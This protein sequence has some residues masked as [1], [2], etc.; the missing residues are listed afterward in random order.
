MRV[1]VVDDNESVRAYLTRFLT[2][3]GWAVMAAA[4][5]AQCLNILTV[6]K[7]DLVIIDI[8]LGSEN[9]ID[10]AEDLRREQADLKILLMSGNPSNAE[11]VE[12][13]GFGEML[14]KPFELS[15]LRSALLKFF[16]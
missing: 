13:A 12:L 11:K 15:K 8:Q 5:R 7:F 1:L 16:R 2:A 3:E 9:G 14:Q 10:L 6:N 4:T